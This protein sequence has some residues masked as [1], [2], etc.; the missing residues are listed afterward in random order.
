[1]PD[2]STLKGKLH[3]TK[4]K[5]LTFDPKT[6]HCVRPWKGDRWEHT[7]YVNRAIH[8]LDP[9]QISRLREYG[10]NVPTKVSAPSLVEPEDE[11]RSLY[12]LVADAPP[13]EKGIELRSKPKVKTRS[14]TEKEKKSEPPQEPEPSEDE[15]DEMEYI[16][17]LVEECG[18]DF[19]GE[20]EADPGPA[21][22]PGGDAVAP[23]GDA[24]DK[25]EKRRGCRGSEG[26]SQIIASYDVSY[27]L[28]ILSVDVCQRLRCTNHLRMRAEGLGPSKPKTLV[29]TLQQITS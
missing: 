4:H 20:P 16:R 14:K 2:G 21:R 10:F 24:K 29:T 5:M 23:D 28:R 7:S 9:S 1:M 13:A 12:D 6:H 8:Q 17:R 26:G 18:T 27:S 15:E 25:D 22:A 19:E 11:V 3:R